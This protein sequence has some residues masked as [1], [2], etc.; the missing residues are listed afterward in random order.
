ME[1]VLNL[2]KNEGETPL[3]CL[4]RFRAS[5]PE[6]K[7]LP[8]SYMGRLDPMASG[9]LLVVAGEEN[10]KREQ[11]L[12]LDKEYECKVLFGFNTDTHDILGLVT[13]SVEGALDEQDIKSKVEKTIPD[14]VGTYNQTYPSFSSKPVGG[15]SLFMHAREGTI[16]K[17]NLPSHE[18][19]VSLIE[20]LKWEQMEAIDLKESIKTRIAKVA[21]D[22]RQSEILSKWEEVLEKEKNRS[23]SVV[24]LRIS[25]GS[26]FYV[27]MFAD[28]LGKKIGVPAL[29][30]EI[31]RTR[32]G[33]YRIEGSKK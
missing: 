10:K 25:C 24:S 27:R 21:G 13:E 12:G 5:H 2:Y 9:V 33:E 14:F 17:D 3:A 22:F 8:L 29:A 18:V 23:F 6:Y 20:I 15:K 28:D 26:G 1:L 32:V 16:D 7:D 4:E 31:V 11:Y 30:F 19:V